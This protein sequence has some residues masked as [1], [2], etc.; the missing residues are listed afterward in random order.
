VVGFTPWSDGET[1]RQD[2]GDLID[3]SF[4]KEDITDFFEGCSWRDESIVMPESQY[5]VNHV[6]YVERPA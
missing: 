6:I 3:L 4:R 1:Y 2:G 5:G